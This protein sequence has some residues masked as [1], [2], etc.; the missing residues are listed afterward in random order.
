MAKTK[1]KKPAPNYSIKRN[2]K[3]RTPPR[4]DASQNALRVV[5]QAM[6]AGI[7]DHVWSIEEMVALTVQK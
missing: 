4:L 2:P 7:T 6:E 1:I 3:A 5:E